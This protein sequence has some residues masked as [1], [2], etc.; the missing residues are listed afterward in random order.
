[1]SDRP[2]EEAPTTPDPADDELD[3]IP[4]LLTRL[5]FRASVDKFVEVAN[6]GPEPLFEVGR[7]ALFEVG[8]GDTS[9]RIVG[10]RDEGQPEAEMRQ[11]AAQYAVDTQAA[12]DELSDEGREWWINL[13]EKGGVYQLIEDVALAHLDV[14]IETEQGETD[15]ETDIIRFR[16]PLPDTDTDEDQA[17]ADV[18]VD[19]YVR[20][21][22]TEDLKLLPE[23]LKTAAHQAVN[24]LRADI[25]AAMYAQASVLANQAVRDKYTA[26]DLAR[27]SDAELDALYLE[28]WRAVVS[29]SG[30]L[31]ETAAH[32]GK[33]VAVLL[34]DIS[35]EQI[36]E[37]V[38]AL[39]RR[40]LK[41]ARR[42]VT[43]RQ[44]PDLPDV[45]K[46]GQ[47]PIPSDY[48]TFA[49]T[50][51]I[52]NATVGKGWTDH[53]GQRVPTHSTPGRRGKGSVHVTVRP[54][55][56]AL[57]ADAD[58]LARLWEQV[59]A[60]DDWTS[61]ALLVCLAHWASRGEAPD[62]P[63]W[64]TA[65]AILDAR[66]IQRKRY[67]KELGD[68]QHGHRTE[69]RM[70]AGRALAQLDSLWL[71]I[72][73]LEVIPAGKRRKPRRITVTSRALAMLD[74][75]SQADLEGAAVFL[76]ARVMPG[77]W[78]AKYWELGLR[79][80]GLLASKVLGY[81]PYRE[82]TEKRLGKYLAF[83]FRFN[84][85]KSDSLIRRDV[86]TLLENAG[87]DTDQRNPQRTR[88][89]LER[90]LDRLAADGILKGWGYV[91]DAGALPARRW[92][93]H[94]LALSV[95]IDPPDEI[96]THYRAIKA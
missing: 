76:A 40:R 84:A 89:R 85:S 33:E 55:D 28:E 94:W 78:A 96:A 17:G 30:M 58:A 14:S 88:D 18:R 37:L 24:D 68:W 3:R 59:R 83:Q 42:R 48:P 90:A 75:M 73:N 31:L 34:A 8:S 54:P 36:N 35:N 49:L 66:G 86:A 1:M 26:D 70:K 47:A 19:D 21:N 2:D 44:V 12:L 39:V 11:G 6:A 95:R 32:W 25:A 45:F 80:T 4:L 46:V 72:V 22:L 87:L 23:L 20:T 81:D 61:D 50:K 93:P 92:L 56:G 74:V 5:V 62:T 69:D 57:T 60:L 67:R 16:V 79:Q 51:A 53:Q 63:V 71:E 64:I 13:A 41:E 7:L 29:E 52:H 15:P 91:L 27:R 38:E 77:E 65:A 43:S 9:L 82:Q 10:L